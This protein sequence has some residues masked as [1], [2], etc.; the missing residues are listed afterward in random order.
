MEA[1]NQTDLFQHYDLLPPPVLQI[2]E[3]FVGEGY[4]D[5][6]ELSEKLKPLGYTFDWGLDGIPYNLRKI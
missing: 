2:V 4:E 6:R 1:T 5:C 3:S